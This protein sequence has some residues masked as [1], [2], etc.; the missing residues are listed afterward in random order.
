MAELEEIKYEPSDI[1]IYKRAEGPVLREKSLL[2]V[3]QSGKIVASGGE[4]ELCAAESGGAVRVLS[5]LR[6]GR[7]ADYRATVVMFSL[8]L[9]MVHEKRLFR[10]PVI[11]VCVPEGIT[12]VEKRAMEDA[13]YQA[14][15]G[16]VEIFEIPVGQFVKELPDRF[17]ALNRKCSVVIGITKDEPEKYLL[18]QMKEI[19]GD[20]AQAGITAERAGS[21]FQE[22]QKQAL[23]KNFT[24]ESK[25]SPGD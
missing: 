2:A 1:V 8:L 5:P 14:G 17:P 22:A 4:A 12:E 7:V 21:L 11:A 16:K 19:A 10:R 13:L 9:H 23:E 18:E 3:D 6:R 15:A 24:Q 20:A 25:K